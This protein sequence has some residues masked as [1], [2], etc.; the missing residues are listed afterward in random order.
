MNSRVTTNAHFI[1]LVTVGNE[2][3]L[4]KKERSPL[5]MHFQPYTHS[6]HYYYLFTIYLPVLDN[7]RASSGNQNFQNQIPIRILSMT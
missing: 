5:T 7:I 4:K 3:F 6:C 2:F 1:S